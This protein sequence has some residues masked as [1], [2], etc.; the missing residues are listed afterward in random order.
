MEAVAPQ[1]VLNLAVAQ[2][3]ILEQDAAIGTHGADPIKLRL[4]IIHTLDEACERV[5]TQRIAD[6]DF[7]LVPV[8][9]KPQ[10]K[11]GEIGAFTDP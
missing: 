2:P 3:D 4:P 5:A 1:T 10:I 8:G 7:D 9:D 6:E 11:I